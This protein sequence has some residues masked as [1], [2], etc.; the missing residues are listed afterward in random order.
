[1]RRCWIG[2]VAV[3]GCAQPSFRSTVELLT[4][5]CT[6]VD[7][8][9]VPVRD[10]TREEFQVYD[11]GTRRIV[12]S[13]WID[14]DQ[15]LTLGILID[16]SESQQ[17]RVDEHRRMALDLLEKVLRPG[18]RAFVVSIGE[19]I[20]LLAD[21]VE[22]SGAA[23][24]QMSA[25]Q[26]KLLGEQCTPLVCGASPLWN[27]LYETARVQMAPLTGN[28]A[29][30]ILTDGFDSGSRHTWRQAADEAQRSGAQVY[31]VQYPSKSGS[32]YAPD[33]YRLV[34][35]AG[36]ASF[37]PADAPAAVVSRIEADL[38]RRYVLGVQ[39]ERLSRKQRHEIRVE[40]TRPDLTVR[41]RKTYFQ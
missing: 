8:H 4:I 21:R 2:L 23:R 11:N 19:E 22:S 35:D 29:L 34:E 33:L 36:G 18:D 3:M 17:D 32:R 20:R 41:A 15:P 26:G 31:A 16:A 12:E 6:V 9:G 30:L 7:S 28:K 5:P 10:L 27:A 38:R 1:M 24:R 39:P 14:T 13:L 37:S 25:G 40:V